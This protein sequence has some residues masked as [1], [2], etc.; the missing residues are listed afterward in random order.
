MSIELPIYLDHHA[1]T[2]VD[3]RVLEAMLP[4]F[5]R[6]F[7]NAAS[8]S[9]VFGWRAEAAVED[10][11]ERIARA[12]GAETR[13]IIF[14]SGAT[15]SNNAAL[16]GVVR[17]RAKRGNHVVTAVTEHRAV[18]DPLRAHE[19]SG[20]RVTWLPVDSDG[21][22][23][24]SAVEEALCDETV[25]VS[26]MAA[27]SEIGVL[28]PIEAI[29]AI[30]RERGVLFHTDAAQA[31]G[32][33]PFDLA[34]LPADLVSISAHKLYGPKGCGA[35]YVRNKRPRIRLE[36][37][38]YGGGHE[39]GL[40]SGTLAVPL[41]VGLARALEICV[42]ELSQAAARA[43]GLRDRLRAA[44]ESGLDGVVLNG[45]PQ[46]RLPGNLNL[47]FE[48]ITADSLLIALKDVAI[49]SGSACSSATPEPSHVLLALGGGAER[50]SSALRFGIGRG[51]TEE[52]IDWV[53]EQVIA[54]V[55]GLRAERRRGA[56]VAQTRRGG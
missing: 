28:Q 41:I 49:S 33:I 20:G 56:S 2:P 37:L 13:E 55:R 31:V 48:G 17:A 27:N 1:T 38:L 5:Q 26:I 53:A 11:R 12:L 24:P 43:A 47:S 8:H 18:L 44:I 23:D 6:D 9:H 15:E 46:Q 25:L 34:S 35:L 45:H 52:E 7:G 30:C 29:A 14:T 19:S 10:A 42:E 21:L 3:S 32:K 51:N 36:P 16:L 39:R 4:Y 22:V 54:S 50:A 40:R